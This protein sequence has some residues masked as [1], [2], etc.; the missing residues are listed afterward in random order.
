MDFNKKLNSKSLLIDQ[1]TTE[2]KFEKKNQNNFEVVDYF[3]NR[4]ISFVRSSQ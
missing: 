2:G 3:F 1:K 4:K